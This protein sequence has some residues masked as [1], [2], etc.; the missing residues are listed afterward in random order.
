MS[1][2]D[3]HPS[4]VD[5]QWWHDLGV[6]ED[7]ESLTDEAVAQW[8]ELGDRLSDVEPSEDVCMDGLDTVNGGDSR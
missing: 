3:G 6:A 5:R 1:A 4:D 7:V 8:R 2:A